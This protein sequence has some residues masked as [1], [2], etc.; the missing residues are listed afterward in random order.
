MFTNENH[1]KNIMDGKLEIGAH[2]LL[3]DLF[4]AFFLDREQSQIIISIKVF[5]FTSAQRVITNCLM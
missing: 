2:S 4:K 5:L 3:F 1:G